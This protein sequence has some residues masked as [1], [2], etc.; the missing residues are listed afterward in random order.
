MVVTFG[1]VYV[2]MFTNLFT[3]ILSLSLKDPI[4]ENI[5]AQLDASSLRGSEF[6]C[7]NWHEI[8]SKGMLWKKLI[9]RKVKTDP[10]W[11]GLGKR[12]GWIKFLFERTQDQES[13]HFYRTLYPKII[14]DIETI[15]SNWR[16][17]K[18]TFQKINCR[19]ETSKGVY[20][21][22]YDDEKIVSGLRD[23]TIKIWDRK[24]LECL[25]VKSSSLI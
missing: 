2:Y 21:L 20:C 6:V 5:L 24:S 15:E 18:H 22:Q 8:I 10:L 16:I 3:L 25:Q 7:R 14:K 17:G 13:H 23:N 12:R 4:A 1:S 19:S 9:E 11:E